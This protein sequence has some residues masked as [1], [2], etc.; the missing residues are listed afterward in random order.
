M[1]I[2][3]KIITLNGK[4]KENKAQYN[5]GKEAANISVLSSGKL[6]MFEYLTREKLAT[7]SGPIQKNSFEYSP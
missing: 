6:D 7:K 4:I 3:D 2:V 1:A 5:L